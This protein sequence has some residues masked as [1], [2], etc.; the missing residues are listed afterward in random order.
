MRAPERTKECRACI[1]NALRKRI[2]LPRLIRTPDARTDNS[3][4]ND[5]HEY[6]KKMHWFEFHSVRSY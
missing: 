2:V 3:A 6:Y 5:K 4:N 1:R